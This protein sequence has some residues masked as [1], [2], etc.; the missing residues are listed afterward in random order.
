MVT[1]PT[2][3][4]GYLLC[5]VWCSFFSDYICNGWNTHLFPKVSERVYV[6][7]K[8]EICTIY[9]SFIST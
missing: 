4:L 7:H 9:F 1:I 3:T 8:Y 6:L 5:S 2:G